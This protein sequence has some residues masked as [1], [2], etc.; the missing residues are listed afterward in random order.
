MATSNTSAGTGTIR[1]STVPLQTP[2]N[3]DI[4][5]SLFAY[6][7]LTTITPATFDANT[8][9]LNAFVVPP[10]DA[11][12]RLDRENQTDK[13]K[14]KKGSSLA[15]R[16]KKITE[17]LENE[18]DCLALQQKIRKELSGLED[19]IDET[20]KEIQRKLDEILP[21]LKLPLNPFKIPKWLKKFALGRILPDL[22]ATINFI[23]RV[24]EVAKALADL[25][26]VIIDLKPKLEACAIGTVNT[27]INE[28]QNAIDQAVQDL[29]DQITQAIG[30]AICDGLKEA[31][32]TGDDIVD[33]L[34]GVNTV[35][36]LLNQVETINASLNATLG[37]SLTRLG[38]NQSL[39]Q[40]ITG[41]P[42]VL[43]T[44]SI[45]AFEQT[46]NSDAYTQYREDINGVLQAGDPVNEELPVITGDTLVG[47]TLTSSNGVW[48]AN[49]ANTIFPITFQ[50]YREN[51]EIA[52]ANTF[53][54]V[55]TINDVEYPLSCRVAAETQ[56]S[57]EEVYTA[58]TAPIQFTMA[59]GDMPTISGSA[60]DGQQLQCSDGTWPY[61][62]T[63]IMFEWIR[64][65]SF[66]ANVRVQ[67]LSA[68]NLYTIK[69]A[70]VGSKIACKVVASSFRYTLSVVTANTSIVV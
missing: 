1:I 36:S 38:D 52:G 31:G 62:P 33:L 50:W 63:S 26:Q 59:P 7:N 3:A 44:S 64:V 60:I 49:G 67:T 34:N 27:I 20:A 9:P 29:Q 47:S 41:L 16:I 58:Q 55:P 54:Y 5:A 69:S 15:R 28:A 35:N 25:T 24:L 68:N 4:S 45:E 19:F 42:P 17:D 13:N 30:E 37:N 10:I 40:D 61:D 48:S 8:I 70:D 65:P 6:Q 57:I 18:T 14:A 12:C 66:G 22:D 21:I 2:T 46:V 32:V 43:D 11:P 39:I 51:Q 23:I 53:T 56:T